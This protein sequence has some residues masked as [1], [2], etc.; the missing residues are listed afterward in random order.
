MPATILLVEHDEMVLTFASSVLRF[1]GYTVLH[2]RNGAEA[3]RMADRVGLEG[4][5]LLLTDVDARMLGGLGLIRRCTQLRPDLKVLCMT[6]RPGRLEDELGYGC[7]TIVKPFGYRELVESVE[8]CCAA[9]RASHAGVG[10][11]GSG[12]G[13]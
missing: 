3:M 1:H 7:Q 6:E 5:D 10:G 12:V 8:A 13:V 11:L 4:I 9:G 2:A